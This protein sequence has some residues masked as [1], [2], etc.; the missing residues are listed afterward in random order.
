MGEIDLA[1]AS[2]HAVLR[3]RMQEVGYVTQ[4][5]KVLPRVPAIDVVAEPLVD[6]PASLR[7]ARKKAISLLERL[8]IPS[9]LFDAYPAT[10]SG[11]EQQRINIARAIIGRPRLLLL[12]E[13]TASLDKK[14]MNIVIE[15]LLDLRNQGTAIV[16]VFHNHSVIE[17]L[18]DEI[19]EMPKREIAD[20][21]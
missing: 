9:E 3:L 14:L 13:P 7:T 17:S 6:G 5:L 21:F 12:D 11:G 8:Q 16:M 19:Y 4:F 20:V 1:T 2:E 15:L 10:F 18:A